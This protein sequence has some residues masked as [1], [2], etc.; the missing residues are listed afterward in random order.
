M[1]CTRV[2]R[3]YTSADNLV[4]G[5]THEG[6]APHL[7]FGGLILRELN[8]DYLTMF[9]RDWIRNAPPDLAFAYSYLNFPKLTRERIV[10]LSNVLSDA[11]NAGYEKLENLVLTAVNGKA[12][13]SI[14]DLKLKLK[15]PGVQRGG[16]EF[17][18][19]EFKNGKQIVLPYAGIDE[20]HRRIGKVYAV[21]DAASFFV[22]VTGAETR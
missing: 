2:L 20:A 6:P 17:A 7:I 14:D 3:R 11:F 13:S 21:T 19:F 5:P 8:A 10:I 18:Q 15:M 22:R 9:G 16:V 1:S 12:V 4:P